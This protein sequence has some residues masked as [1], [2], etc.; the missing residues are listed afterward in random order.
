M[1]HIVGQDLT[2]VLEHGARPRD[3]HRHGPQGGRGAGRQG[4]PPN[5]KHGHEVVRQ[6][7]GSA[8]PQAAAPEPG[9]DNGEHSLRDVISAAQALG[10]SCPST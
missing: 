10:A 8:P 2:A 4:L 9:P 1:F 3:H 5:H 6:G 7:P